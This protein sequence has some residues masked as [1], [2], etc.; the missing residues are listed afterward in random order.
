[1]KLI[2][3]DKKLSLAGAV[4]VTVGA[5]IGVGIFIIV[6]PIGRD[7]G[8]WLPLVFALAA[9]P[10]Y[11]GAASSSALGTTIPADGGGYY[12]TRSLLGPYAGA[13]TSMLIVIGAMGALAT[14]SVGIADYLAL[15]FP[16]F[17][18]PVTAI[19]LILGTWLINYFGL[20]ASEKFQIA[21][22]VQLISGLLLVIVAG[23]IGGGN[24][25]FSQPLPKGVGGFVG[26][27]VLACLAYTG[28]NIVGELGDEVENPRRNVPI[29]ILLGLGIVAVLYTGCA[30]VVGGTLTPAEMGSSK[31]ALMDAAMHHLPPW[32][33]HYINLAALGAA[34]T[35]INAVFL[36][37]PREF[38]ALAEDGV[39]PKWFLKFNPKRQTFDNGMYVVLAVGCAMMLL[40]RKA[41]QWGL[42]CVAGLLLSNV[43]LSIAAFF[44]FKKFPEKVKTSPL[45]LH[46]GWVYP[47]AAL[48]ALFSLAFGALSFTQWWPVGVIAAAGVVTGL[49]LT[50]RAIARGECGER[51]AARE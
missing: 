48:S 38:T 20:M 33:Q 51:S 2:H 28:F 44:I 36:A 46:K 12:Y 47:C 3:F 39:L 6:G 18:R 22:V 10:A 50:A 45:P 24:P 27:M 26:A 34:I 9:I 35:S 41:D 14:V 11:F 25:D 19:V 16:D 40:V 15:Y 21:M 30:W 37:V 23:L 43:V 1:M 42:M 17:P 8:A 5:I 29:T 49:V 4:C 13:A 32:T 31:V 7:S